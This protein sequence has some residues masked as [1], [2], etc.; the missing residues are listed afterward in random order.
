MKR[1]A[2]IHNLPMAYYPPAFNLMKVAAD[3]SVDVTVVTTRAQRGHAL[4]QNRRVRVYYPIRERRGGNSILNLLRQVYFVLY[5]LLK[6]L[7]L[8]PD[9]VLYYESSSAFAPCLY[10][11]LRGRKAVICAHYHEYVE[12]REYN[13]PGMRLS[14]IAQQW[15]ERYMLKNCLWVSQTNSFRMDFF[16]QDYPFLTDTQCHILPNYPPQSWK[17]VTKMHHGG[18]IKCVLIGSLSL[19]N[20][21]L[22]EFCHWVNSQK[23]KIY[24]DFYA[25]NFHSEIKKFFA[26]LSS[27]YITLHPNGISYHAIPSLLAKYDVGLLLYKPYSINVNYCETNKLYEYLSCGLDVWYPTTMKLIHSMDK[28]QFAPQI[29]A[30]DVTTQHFPHLNT[31]SRTVDNGSFDKFCEPVYHNFLSSIGLIEQ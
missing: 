11:M 12:L 25:F 23:G 21:F 4:E 8:R 28:S 30:F 14:R 10:R 15:E 3:R 17:V 2:I 16:R 27:P 13:R 1:L 19:Q 9:V 29:E 24:I 26:E 20:L 7:W 22:R 31:A 5:A 18:A 6:L